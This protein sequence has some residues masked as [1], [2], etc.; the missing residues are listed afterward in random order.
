[1]SSSND[2]RALPKLKPAIKK[3]WL[4][5]LR[6]GDYKQAR[7]VLRTADEGFCCLG[8]LADV[9]KDD[10]GLKLEW[11]ESGEP[12]IDG[13]WLGLGGRISAH[14]TDVYFP[15]FGPL[16]SRNDGGEVKPQSFAQIA[17]IIERRM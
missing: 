9:V 6:S 17:N 4:K 1:M 7:S 2:L 8:V 14:V 12:S 16:V 5:A 10:A 3:R 15:D 11:S 13:S